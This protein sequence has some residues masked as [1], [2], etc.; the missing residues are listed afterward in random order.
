MSDEID[1]EITTRKVTS[2]PNNSVDGYS[3]S[4]QRTTKVNNDNSAIGLILGVLL[5][6]GLGGGAVVYYLNNRPA[7]TQIVPGP[8]NTVKENE[9]TIIERNNTNTKEVNPATQQPVPKVEINVPA[10]AATTS[11]Q[12][13]TPTP[14]ATTSPQPVTPTPAATAQPQTASPTPSSTNQ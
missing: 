13:V 4:E 10:P 6:L 11:P 14:A 12:P 7:T 1:R 8:T 3:V 5:T 2:T 9:T